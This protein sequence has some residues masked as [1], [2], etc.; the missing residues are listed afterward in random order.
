MRLLTRPLAAILV[1]L[2]CPLASA[3]Q[4]QIRKTPLRKQSARVVPATLNDVR[5][6]AK[7]EVGMRLLGSATQ[8]PYKDGEF[9]IPFGSQLTLTD[10][11]LRAP[12][13]YTS[14]RWSTRSSGIVSAQ[15]QVVQT[16]TSYGFENWEYPAGIVAKGAAKALPKRHGDPSYFVVDLRTIYDLP[17]EYRL[18]PP[19]PRKTGKT[20]LP[21]GKISIRRNLMRP[22]ASAAPALQVKRTNFAHSMATLG[23]HRMYYVR[24][25][26]LGASKR[27]LA[28]TPYV[29]IRTGVPSSI[30]VHPGSFPETPPPTTINVPDIRIVDYKPPKY[31]SGE[32]QYYRFVVLSNC[33]KFLQDN[34]GWKP[35]TKVFLPP[36]RDEGIDSIGDALG[37]AFDAVSDLVDWVSGVWSDLQAKFVDGIC[38]GNSDCKKVAGPALKAGLMYVGIPPELPNSSDLCSMGKDY[39]ASY[40]ASQTNVPESAIREG[41]D[42]MADVVN[43]PP[44]GPGGTFLWPDPDFQN[45][46]PTV[47]VEAKNTSG[48]VT[49]VTTLWL[50]YGSTVGD[51][52]TYVPHIPPWLDTKT[53]I[54]PLQPGQT[55]SFPIFLT[56]NPETYISHG[57]DRRSTYTGRRVEIYAKGNGKPLYFGETNWHGTAVAD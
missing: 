47:I 57:A 44:G 19:I 3:Q 11:Q 2:L 10:E 53:P 13:L 7:L 24:L 49:D 45:K 15:W 36:K 35:G 14:F 56:P 50:L 39:I 21:S 46:P 38:G 23:G 31:F 20:Q 48:E 6:D 37:A 26:V 16:P 5:F 22:V 25:V 18:S 12:H 41:I 55:L 28:I 40:V 29:P 54:P 1:L 8:T 33:P 51:S 4:L 43:N 42:R 9:A 30:T 32:D 17:Q 52:A 27:P 34:M